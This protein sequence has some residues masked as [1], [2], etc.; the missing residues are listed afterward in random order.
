MFVRPQDGLDLVPQL[1]FYRRAPG[2]RRCWRMEQLMEGLEGALQ[3][4]LGAADSPL[5]CHTERLAGP[6]GAR[7]GVAE[8]KAGEVVLRAGRRKG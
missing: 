3:P 4:G 5:L 7:E 6:W 2:R 1:M 8:V